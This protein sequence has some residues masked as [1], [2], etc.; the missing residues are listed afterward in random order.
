MSKAEKPWALPDNQRYLLIF[1]IHQNSRWLHRVLEEESGNY[2]HLILGGDYFDPY[3]PY[4]Y[5]AT[6]AETAE[7]YN[8]L[9]DEHG[10]H[11]TLLW[12]NHDLPYLVASRMQDP[13][14]FYHPFSDLK[15]YDTQVAKFFAKAIRPEFWGSGQLFA[16][17]HGFLISHAGVA[18][19]FWPPSETR[20]ASLAQLWDDCE[21]ALAQAKQ[22]R[23]S[24]LEPGR[25]RGGDKQE[26]GGIIWQDWNMEFSD[27]DIPLPQIVGHT[28]SA[29]AARQ[30]GRSWCLDGEQSCY[31]LLTADG[32]RLLSI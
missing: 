1:D 25:V 19:E 16:T 2:D 21:L 8:E 9:L 13:A 3:E 27:E 11:L 28:R 7:A 17:A 31:G 10:K 14:F 12:G 15:G 20:E 29:E 24:I 6:D 23:H 4:P 26:R 32:L 5:T 30:K 22:R 18:A